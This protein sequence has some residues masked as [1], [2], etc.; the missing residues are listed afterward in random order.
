MSIYL[1]GLYSAQKKLIGMRFKSRR[2]QQLIHLWLI[3]KTYCIS[4]RIGGMQGDG[5]RVK[6]FYILMAPIQIIGL[7]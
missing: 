3:I 1:H 4:A 5:A 6:F 2:P 7:G